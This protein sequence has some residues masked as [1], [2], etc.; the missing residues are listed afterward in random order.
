MYAISGV[1]STTSAARSIRVSGLPADEDHGRIITASERHSSAIEGENSKEKVTHRFTRGTNKICTMKKSIFT[2]AA[3]STSSEGSQS[4]RAH[5][6]NSNRYNVTSDLCVSVLLTEQQHAIFLAW[7]SSDS[8]GEM[9][10]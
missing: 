3:A 7:K 4:K 10:V 6:C 1:G 9:S 5:R 2:S 8:R